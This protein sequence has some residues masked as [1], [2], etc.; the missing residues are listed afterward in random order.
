MKNTLKMLGIVCIIVSA[1]FIAACDD[2]FEMDKTFTVTFN[3]NGGTTVSPQIGI[4]DGGYATKPPNPSYVG[5]SSPTT[6]GLYKDGSAA[7]TPQF[8]NWYLSLTDPTPFNFTSTPITGNI[9]LIAK[10]TDGSSGGSTLIDVSGATGFGIF[11]KAISY[12]TLST[13]TPQGDGKYTLVLSAAEND[14]E[15]N[16]FISSGAILLNKSNLKLT[17]TSSSVA[18]RTIKSTV[19]SGVFLI[20]SG[21]TTSLTLKNIALQGSGNEVDD[22]LVRIQNG[23][24]LTLGNQSAV[25]GHKN[26]TTVGSGTKG[27]GSAVCVVGA[28]LIMQEG[29]VIED[30]ESTGSQANKNLVGGVYTIASGSTGPILKITGGQVINNKCT[31]GQT[32]DVYATEGGSFEFG[33]NVKI[34]EIT[35]NGDAPG[36]D[37]PITTDS[38]FNNAVRAVITVSNLGTQADVKL[39]LRS[40]STG[41]DVVKKVWTNNAVLIAPANGG[42][43]SAAD[44]RKFNLNQ[45]KCY[46]GTPTSQDIGDGYKI[47]DSGADIGKLVVVTQ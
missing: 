10:W 31:E 19:T 39:S 11:Q 42:T 21:S 5:T 46:S 29:S 15:A 8:D 45:F 35:L 13:F 33:G 25:R 7:S 27:N 18:Q 22:S 28:T 43:L 36:N 47:S 34:S 23:A 1:L 37:A 3:S 20:L 24:T 12:L 9:T 2:L 41:L 44:V 6:A 38:N 26:K 14:S 32:R 16:A 17:I 30:N 4:K 40:T